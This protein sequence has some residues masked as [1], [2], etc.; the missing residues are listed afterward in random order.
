MPTLP[1][2]RRE[3]AGR[4]HRCCCHL[5]QL[6][7]TKPM[8]KH[9]QQ[10]SLQQPSLPPRA[11]P[12]AQRLAAWPLAAAPEWR[13]PGSALEGGR[14]GK[15]TTRETSRCPQTGLALRLSP[16][17]PPLPSPLPLHLP[18][19][20]LPG[21]ARPARTSLPPQPAA[22]PQAGPGRLRRHAC[23]H[24]PYRLVLPA[25]GRRTACRWP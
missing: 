14:G 7:G 2:P 4:V 17:P 9:L 18:P 19:A 25:A 3:G 1:A 22:R 23:G 21:S 15:L 20:T 16:S 12:Q 13:G 24:R 11:G 10:H 6:W 5:W 8:R